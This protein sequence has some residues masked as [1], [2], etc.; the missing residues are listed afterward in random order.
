MLDDYRSLRKGLFA[1][2]VVYSD[3]EDRLRQWQIRLSIILDAVVSKQFEMLISQ[4]RVM[5]NQATT[6][7]RR[8]V[9]EQEKDPIFD[10][11]TLNAKGEVTEAGILPLFPVVPLGD[12]EQFFT[13][14][15]QL[16]QWHK[17]L[18]TFLDKLM[19]SQD[20]DKGEEA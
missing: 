9:F 11:F 20:G 12:R 16:T 15:S 3:V 14:I 19:Y 2:L 8:I 7:A 17:E 4:G 5:I 18:I 1:F 13:S 6:Q 10:V